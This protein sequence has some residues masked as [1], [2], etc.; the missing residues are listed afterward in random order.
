MATDKQIQGLEIARQKIIARGQ[1][2]KQKILDAAIKI[3]CKKT[4]QLVTRT[5][6]ANEA[7]VA[8]SLVTYHLGDQSE[9]IEAILKEAIKREI[10]PIILRGLIDGHPIIMAAP[11]DLRHKARMLL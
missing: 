11:A 1:E 10:L 5:E 2:T 9:I 7:E 6:I 8:N 4:Y 3:A